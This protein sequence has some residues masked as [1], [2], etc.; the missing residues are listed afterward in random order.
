MLGV[1]R[2]SRHEAKSVERGQWE[3]RAGEIPAG[4]AGIEGPGGTAHGSYKL[5]FG[6]QLLLMETVQ[7]THILGELFSGQPE[8]TSH[9]ENKGGGKFLL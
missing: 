7:I 5:V 6:C 4:V 9:S 3:V 1:Q 8:I 2:R